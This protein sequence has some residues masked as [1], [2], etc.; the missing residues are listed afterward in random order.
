MWLSSASARWIGA[1]A[2]RGDRGRRGVGGVLPVE[3]DVVGGEGLP[4]VPLDA[5]LEPPRD[6]PAVPRQAAVLDAR[7]LLGQDRHEV[8]VGVEGGER[9]VEEAGAVGVGEP[10]GEVRVQQGGA[11][12]PERPEVP[13]AAAARGREG[14]PGRR[15]GQ[16]DRGQHLADQR[17]RQAGPD[18]HA[19]ELPPRD[20]AV[21]ARGEASVAARGRPSGFPSRARGGRMVRQAG[22]GALPRRY[23]VLALSTVAGIATLPGMR[24]GSSRRRRPYDPRRRGGDPGAPHLSPSARRRH[25]AARVGRRRRPHSRDRLRAVP[26]G[27]DR[28]RGGRPARPAAARAGAPVRVHAGRAGAPIPPDARARGRIRDDLASRALPAGAP[29]S[30]PVP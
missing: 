1:V 28:R 13:A 29:R 4:V 6:R 23:H 14:R 19:R 15:L 10:G 11:L 25:A 12:P 24:S 7:E 30:P 8:P 16:A 20:G 22:G 27:P 21:L 18:H 2:S 26:A 5:L 3:E 17:G 9:L